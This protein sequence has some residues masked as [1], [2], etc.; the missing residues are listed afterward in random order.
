[1]FDIFGVWPGERDGDWTARFDNEW[2]V[3]FHSVGQE[4]EALVNELEGTHRLSQIVGDR[5]LQREIL[6]QAALDELSHGRQ[7]RGWPEVV[8]LITDQMT[9]AVVAVPIG[10]MR[11]SAVDGAGNARPVRL[12]AHIVAGHLD[13]SLERCVDDLAK[14]HEL[15]GFRFSDDSWWTE[16]LM[17]AK[18]DPQAGAEILEGYA[19]SESWPRFV[20]ASAVSSSGS[21][22]E[23]TG[24]LNA[25]A[26]IGALVLLDHPPGRFWTEETPWIPG[27]GVQ[28][29]LPADTTSDDSLPATQPQVVDGRA[30][31]LQT[32]ISAPSLGS[33][34]SELDAG[35]HMTGIGRDLLGA[36]VSPARRTQPLAVSCRLALHAAKTWSPEARHS[37]AA[38]AIRILFSEFDDPDRASEYD[39]VVSDGVKW[40]VANDAEWPSHSPYVEYTLQP[41]HWKASLPSYEHLVVALDLRPH[42]IDMNQTAID[43]HVLLNVVQAILFGRAAALPAETATSRF[44]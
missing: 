8:E 18:E 32:A 3:A 13:D 14:R 37:L 38:S 39:T 44:T 11:S 33:S 4:I 2:A 9:R 5:E 42:N 20:I 6:R 24:V 28:A 12:G 36:I 19:D 16:D 17:A 7:D 43:G 10:G 35:I 1:M 41:G 21:A 30:M 40:R 34:R 23:I 15:V 25:E 22:A 27:H 31:H 26:L 29:E